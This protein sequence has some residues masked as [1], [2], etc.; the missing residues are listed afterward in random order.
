MLSRRDV[1]RGT[2]G[3]GAAF[4]VGGTAFAAPAG[5]EIAW[6][7]AT[8]LIPAF[9]SGELS[10]V[11]VLEAQI[12]RINRLNG[13]VNCITYQHFDEALA[14]ARESERRY[15]A[16]TAR[17]LEGI[18]VAV[19][20]E[21]AVKGWVTTMGTLLRKDAPPEQAD[22]PVIEGLRAAGAVFP[23]QTTVPEF[24]SWATTATRLWG[25]TRDP[26]NLRY[27]PG[28]S[29]GGTGAALAAGF[30]TLGLGSDMGGSI[31]IPSSQCGLYGFKPPFGRIPTS[32]IVYET[33]GPLAR[34]F[35]DLNLFTRAMVGPH[36]MVHSSLSPRL[37]FPAT[38][39]PIEGW[40]IAFDPGT[41]VTPL[42][43]SVRDALENGL[44]RLRELG[45][46]I[47]QVDLDFQASDLQTFNLGLFSTA[48]GALLSQARRDPDKLTPYV[49][50][51][52]SKLTHL[53]PDQLAAADALLARYNRR[54][55]EQVFQRGCRALIMPTL[56]TPFIPAEHGLDPAND[57]VNVD[58]KPVRGLNF[59][60]TWPWNLL[61]RY[62]VVSAPLGLGPEDMPIGMQIIG[63]R[64][65]DLGAFQVAAAYSRVGPPLYAGKAFPDFEG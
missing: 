28:G 40:R 44:A 17:P 54:V 64:F 45:A 53:G 1:L 26:W 31:R 16:G 35:D 11:A 30:T 19:K 51:L 61:S 57:S 10:P 32:E 43:P 8:R 56:A 39:G 9:R 60:L 27:S 58:G 48:L 52:A 38:Y 3:I 21:Y 6:M 55:Q 42:D 47:E 37:D 59:L 62:P 29:S 18:T 14:A 4:A 50:E 49:R 34:T 2:G 13:K 41:G 23:I 20:D 33:E 15:R 12:R 5:E 46:S 63:D 36:P 65:D 7:P 22:G 24:Y 25:I